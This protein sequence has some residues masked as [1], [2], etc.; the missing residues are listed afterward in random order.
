[1]LKPTTGN[2]AAGELTLGW[3]NHTELTIDAKGDGSPVTQADRAAERLLRE[4]IEAEYPDDAIHGE[5]EADKPGTSGRRWVIDPI[6]GTTNRPKS[7]IQAILDGDRLPL[8]EDANGNPTFDGTNGAGD[9]AGL[10]FI[11]RA[12]QP[13]IHRNE[14]G[15]AGPFP[16]EILQQVRDAE[17]SGKGISG[18]AHTEVVPEE[19]HAHEPNDAA[20]QDAQ[21]HHQR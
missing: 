9:A 19:P 8:G 18:V 16:E 21:R 1:M 7:V 13:G 3:F 10:G 12:A 17:G 5:E 4:M 15:G 11:A 2:A 20:G 14:R 6:D